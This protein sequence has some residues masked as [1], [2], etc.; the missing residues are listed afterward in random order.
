MCVC[1][2]V[3]IPIHAD[4]FSQLVCRMWHMGCFHILAIGNSATVNT[5]V[6]VGFRISVCVFFGYMP[7]VKLLDHVVVL[8]LI[9]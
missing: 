7:G 2:R 5:G 4:F 3:Y 8:L 1:V 6:H 9:L